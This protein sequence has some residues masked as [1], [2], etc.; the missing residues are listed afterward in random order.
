MPRPLANLVVHR[1]TVEQ[2]PATEIRN[3]FTIQAAL[4]RG[5]KHITLHNASRATEL[6]VQRLRVPY[7]PKNRPHDQPYECLFGF[8]PHS[9]SSNG[10][11]TTQ[12][13]RVDEY[14]EM[15]NWDGFRLEWVKVLGEGG[16]GMATLW[17]A[18]FEDGSSVKAVI[19]IP[20][21]SSANFDSELQW[22]LRYAGASHVTQALDLQAMADN[23]R[24]KMNRGYMINRG[25]RFNPSDLD[26]LVLEYA[27][28]GSMFDLL[29]RA[30]H[31]NIVFSMKALWEIWEC[32]VKGAVSV[33]LQPDAIRRWGH[34]G[35]DKVLESLDD[36]DN[37]DELRRIC[38]LIDSHDVHFDIEEQNI[39]IAEDEQHG[40]HPIFKLH[41]FGEFS[42]K[43]RV[44]WAFW[45]ESEYW[46]LRRV[47]KVN[48]IPPE[49][50]AREWDT[51]D[52]ANP[53]PLQRF[54]GDTFG[55][56]KNVS[57]GRYGTWTNLFLIGQIMEAVITK[58]WVSHPM[59]TMRF[60][61]YDGRSDGQTYG[62]R[63]CRQEYAWIEEDLR[64]LILQCQ[65]EKPGDRPPLAYLLQKIAERKQRGFPEEP[66]WQTRQFWD[67]FWAMQR[68]SQYPE[69]DN[70]QNVTEYENDGFVTAVQAL[71]QH[72]PPPPPAPPPPQNFM[73]N[74]YSANDYE[75]T[76]NP[77]IA[78]VAAL[79]LK[80]RR[81]PLMSAS[82]A[83][84]SVR[85]PAQ[86][87]PYPPSGGDPSASV[88]DMRLS[89]LAS[90]APLLGRPAAQGPSTSEE[91]PIRP[92]A[93]RVQLRMPFAEGPSGQDQEQQQHPARPSAPMFGRPAAEDCSGEEFPIRPGATVAQFVRP[94]PVAADT[95]PIPDF[96]M[97]PTAEGRPLR[98]PP[99]A[100]GPSG[101][102][103]SIRPGAVVVQLGRAPDAQGSSGEEFPIRPG[104]TIAQARPPTAE[105]SSSEGGGSSSSEQFPIRATAVQL[106]PP[107]VDESSSSEESPM[108]ST[109]TEAQAAPSAGEGPSG[110]EFPIRPTT[111]TAAQVRPPADDGSLGKE[112]SMRPDTATTTTTVQLGQPLVIQ[113]SSSEEFPIWATGDLLQEEPSVAKS[114][115]SSAEFPMRP[116]ATVAATKKKRSA[117]EEAA[118][119]AENTTSNSPRKKQR[120]V[121]F[122]AA[123]AASTVTMGMQP[124][125]LA[126]TATDESPGTLWP[127]VANTPTPNPTTAVTEAEGT[128]G[129]H[130]R[131][132][133]NQYDPGSTVSLVVPETDSRGRPK[134]DSKRRKLAKFFRLDRL[135]NKFRR[136][137]SP[138]AAGAVQVESTPELGRTSRMMDV[139]DEG[140][141]QHGEATM[142]E[143]DG[144]AVMGEASVSR[145]RGGVARNERVWWGDEPRGGGNAGN[146]ATGERIW[147]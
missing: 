105:G 41:D 125:H 8:P 123:S 17:N 131:S 28:R 36:P 124:V 84:P 91:F 76:G 140:E 132:L 2:T 80:S 29:N 138:R 119:E 109:A 63:I 5:D 37:M 48:R 111:A 72:A 16:F 120:R 134:K 3:L 56:D 97:R 32:L 66:D 43:M 77:L 146:T 74:P 62:W 87:H 39:L 81:S 99:A 103:F 15:L 89:D 106:G 50:I 40:H 45:P 1:K 85:P 118:E 92:G 126:E 64:S 30:S 6:D 35:L 65:Y 104:A 55:P 117:E 21:R 4:V 79:R 107:P 46:R 31:F 93:A 54:V 78:H 143:D 22:H 19:K 14:I 86:H 47:P 38:T 108:R 53:G 121:R 59:A 96:F 27:D 102:E 83:G 82:E 147:W 139:D 98:R 88:P 7:H 130:M 13:K 112:S 18:I 69:D 49:T 70:M 145:G 100:L 128:Y 137:P 113:R 116:G 33:A 20:V 24:R 42:H 135:R 25:A 136:T 90:T 101:E 114:S 129:D 94:P 110:E 71:E 26:V 133:H 60:R 122:D 115:S 9:S 142:D 95:S 52:P 58:L 127:V 23:V 67:L 144:D 44:N 61:P 141:Q 51:F 34:D 11:D 12:P 75:E 57:A 68:P 73:T 10:G